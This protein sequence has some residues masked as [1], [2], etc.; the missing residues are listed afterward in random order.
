MRTAVVTASRLE[1]PAVEYV[2]A[3]IQYVPEAR[4]KDGLRMDSQ[5]S[6]NYARASMNYQRV[7][8]S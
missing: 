8:L 4:F 1:P 7:H 5:A 2:E 3:N 6:G